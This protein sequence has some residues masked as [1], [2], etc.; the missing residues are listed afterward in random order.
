MRPL[1][2]IL[3]AIALFGTGFLLFKETGKNMTYYYEVD[4]VSPTLLRTIK[5]S[6]IVTP[7]SLTRDPENQR[8]RF[9]IA[10]KT[11]TYPVV[12]RGT[13]PDIF[14]EGIQVVVTGKFDP[15]GIFIASE[16]LAKCPS[17][18]LPQGSPQDFSDS[19]PFPI[20]HLAP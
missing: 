11:R 3:L 12:Y 18:Y 14:R 16:L 5:M 19:A 2:L 10:G 1:L 15:E 4:E 7:G 6:G 17:K 20:T 9:V 8:I 13:V